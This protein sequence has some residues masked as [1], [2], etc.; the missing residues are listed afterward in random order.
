MSWTRDDTER[1]LTKYPLPPDFTYRGA[2]VRPRYN[3]KKGYGFWLRT[4]PYHQGL[5]ERAHEILA[6]LVTLPSPAQ[7]AHLI[8][9]AVKAEGTQEAL[10]LAIEPTPPS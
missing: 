9:E 6:L 10:P 5:F 4:T 1:F 2:V 7:L 3:L 8:N